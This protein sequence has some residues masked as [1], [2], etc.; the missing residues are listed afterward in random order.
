MKKFILLAMA[1]LLTTATLLLAS[2]WLQR[3][4]LNYN[5]QGRYF[6]SAHSVVYDEG[7][8]VFYGLLTAL[9]AALAI[10]VAFWTFKAWR[11]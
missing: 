7:A 5:E 6:D 4:S 10:P 8:I 3:M 2:V 9:M 1:T 11:R